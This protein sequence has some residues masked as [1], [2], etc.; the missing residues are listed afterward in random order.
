MK[1]RSQFN[2]NFTDHGYLHS[3]VWKALYNFEKKRTQEAKHNQIFFQYVQ[4]DEIFEI[5]KM[6]KNMLKV[7]FDTKTNSNMQNSMMVAFIC[8]KLKIATRFVKFWPEN[9]S[10][11]FKLKLGTETNLDMK[12]SIVMFIFLCFYTE[13]YFPWNFV[14]KIKIVCW[15]WNL[16]SRLIWICRIRW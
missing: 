13:V 10:C 12:N 11:Q 15:N 16:E 1:F 7:K 2:H 5:F 4:Y 14:P 8:F 9:R 6:F 3:A